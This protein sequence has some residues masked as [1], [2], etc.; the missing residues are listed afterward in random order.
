M[1]T[2]MP[3]RGEWQSLN[4][5]SIALVFPHRLEEETAVSGTN[6]KCYGS[7]SPVWELPMMESGME[8]RGL[9][10]PS[11]PVQARQE[12]EGRQHKIN[13]IPPGWE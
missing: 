11:G 10:F 5:A 13:R 6:A 12:K 7:W 3:L 1:L 9:S 2:G 8:V 4:Q